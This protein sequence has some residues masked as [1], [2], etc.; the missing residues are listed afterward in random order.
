LAEG[1]FRYAEK[2]HYGYE[3]VERNFDEALRLYRQAAELGCRFDPQLSL[4]EALRGE[5]PK[6]FGPSLS[7]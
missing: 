4:L 2:L 6:L 3:G 5:E 1:R 7:V